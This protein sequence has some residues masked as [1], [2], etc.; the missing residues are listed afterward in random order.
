MDRFDNPYRPGAGSAPPA[1]VGR[2]D[3]IGDFEVT[4]R[5]AQDGRPGKSC[6]LVGPRGV[7]RRWLP[8]L[9][10]VRLQGVPSVSGTGSKSPSGTLHAQ[11]GADR[12]RGFVVPAIAGYVAVSLAWVI[13][14]RWSPG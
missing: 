3:L 12:G 9:L 4:V 13:L 10:A 2:D 1:L 5:R 8:G 6:V 7:G 11:V 14:E